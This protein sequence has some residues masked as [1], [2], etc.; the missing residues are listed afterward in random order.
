MPD[1][2]GY[3]RIVFEIVIR[4]HEIEFAPDNGFRIH[5]HDRFGSN[6]GRPVRPD[7]CYR[8][9]VPF[10]EQAEQFFRHCNHG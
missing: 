10:R 9:R 2:D 8:D 6:I 7:G 4:L 1:T 5:D 3:T